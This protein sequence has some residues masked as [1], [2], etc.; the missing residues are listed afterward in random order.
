[1]I[2]IRSIYNILGYLC[3]LFGDVANYADS[4]SFGDDPG[5]DSIRT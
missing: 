1:M 5:D 3:K 2:L 4:I